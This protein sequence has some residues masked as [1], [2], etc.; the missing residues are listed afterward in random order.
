LDKMKMSLHYILDGYNIINQV[1]FARSK[2][3]D[4]RNS[5]IR[6]IE[7]FRPHG[8]RNNEVT[9]VFDGNRNNFSSLPHS[10][11][12][13][14]F[15]STESADE[16]IM[17]YI[18]RVSHPKQF[19][20]VSDDREIKFF[21]RALGAKVLSVKGFMSRVK[22]KSS[23]TE[24]EKKPLSPDKVYKITKELEEIWLKEE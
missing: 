1:H 19:V 7:K 14:V 11:I 4:G 6:F 12:K 8:S 24:R 16:W 17:G 9:V 2:L 15:S 20:V 5:L 3:K 23:S 13:V 22:R 18:E 10:E 21:V